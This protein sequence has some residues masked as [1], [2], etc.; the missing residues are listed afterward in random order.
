MMR[1]PQ[2]RD[3]SG[4]CDGEGRSLARPVRGRIRIVEFAGSSIDMLCRSRDVNRTTTTR[5]LPNLVV[6]IASSN[7]NATFKTR[8]PYNKPHAV[9]CSGEDDEIVIDGPLNSHSQRSAP[10]PAQTHRNDMTAFVD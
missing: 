4:E 6:D 7:R 9:P 8:R 2:S 1:E 5:T 3:T 10:Q